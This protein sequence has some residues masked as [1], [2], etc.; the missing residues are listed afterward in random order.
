MYS[1]LQN[2][3]SNNEDFVRKEFFEEYERLIIEEVR[4][5]VNQGKLT[6][7]EEDKKLKLE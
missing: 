4:S 5:N 2:L 6:L 1:K 7:G 3:N